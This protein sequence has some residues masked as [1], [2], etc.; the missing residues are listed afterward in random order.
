ME[1][2]DTNLIGKGYKPPDSGNWKGRAVSLEEG[3]QYW[4]QKVQLTNWNKINADTFSSERKNI[5]LLGYACE[6]GVNRNQGRIGAKKGPDAIRQKLARQAWH[7]VDQEVCDFGDVFCVDGDMES[8][9]E[10]LG[11]MVND[12]LQKQAFPI[13]I[14]G[15]HDIAFGHYLGI[16]QFLNEHPGR[17]LGIINFDAHFDLRTPDVSGN[18]GTPFYQIAMDVKD[19]NQSFDYL[20]IGIQSAANTRTLFDIARNLGVKYLPSEVCSMTYF[21]ELKKPLLSFLDRSDFIYISI[22]L[23]GFSSAH[24]PGVSAPSPMGMDPDFVFRML[25]LLFESGKVIS[26]DLAE[27]NPEYDRDSMTALLAARLVEMVARSC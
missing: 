9:Q 11:R 21:P 22:D 25:Q 8:C 27:M 15:G 10:N 7:L 18:S 4:Y 19:K 6:E 20:A 12:L 23:D 16:S 14:G 2:R 24:A 1:K 13:V 5:A 26:C 3:F 17:K